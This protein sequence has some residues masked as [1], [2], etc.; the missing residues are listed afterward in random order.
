VPSALEC[1]K[2]TKLPRKNRQLKLKRGILANGTARFARTGGTAPKKFSGSLRR[3]G[4][5]IR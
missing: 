1:E 3:T 2:P 5:G 4:S